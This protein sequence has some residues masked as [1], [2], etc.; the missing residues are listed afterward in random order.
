MCTYTG[1]I[2]SV[3]DALAEEPVPDLPGEHA[4][5]LRLVLR[6]LFD[7]G[8]CGDARLGATDL[9]RLDRS[10]LIVP[11]DKNKV[12]VKIE[13]VVTSARQQGNYLPCVKKKAL[14]DVSKLIH[15]LNTL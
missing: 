5:A 15:F 4:R 14:V 3:A 11:A 7:D 13:G 1:D 10:R 8:W 2:V 12:S 6:D 9:P